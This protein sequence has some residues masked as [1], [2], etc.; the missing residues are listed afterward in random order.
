MN[1]SIEDLYRLKGVIIT[2]IEL[3]QQQLKLVNQDI[4][5]KLNLLQ[6]N[7]KDRDT[8]NVD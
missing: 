8:E 1:K 6:K 5:N 2:N 7:D 4:L 3:F